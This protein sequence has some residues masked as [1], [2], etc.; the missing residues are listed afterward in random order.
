L[1]SNPELEFLMVSISG[2]SDKRSSIF[3]PGF[4]KTVTLGQMTVNNIEEIK[5]P[6]MQAKGITLVAMD[7]V[8]ETLEYMDTEE[9]DECVDKMGEHSRVIIDD[10][11][12]CDSMKPGVVK[13]SAFKT[14]LDH[15]AQLVTQSNQIYSYTTKVS[16]DAMKRQDPLAD[17]EIVNERRETIRTLAEPLERAGHPKTTP[18]YRI[19]DALIAKDIQQLSK[20]LESVFLDPKKCELLQSCSRREAKAIVDTFQLVLAREAV[21]WGQLAHPNLL[22]FYGLYLY[23]NRLSLVSPWAENGTLFDFMQKEKKAKR[24]QWETRLLLCS[25]VVEGIK[26]LHSND[27]IH[28][29]LKACNILV[30]KSHRAYLADFGFASVDQ[31]DL[32]NWSKHYSSLCGGDY[33]HQSPETAIDQVPNTKESD[34]FSFSMTCVEVF[35]GQVPFPNMTRIKAA[36]AI[37]NGKRPSLDSIPELTPELRQLVHDCWE[38]EPRNRPNIVEVAKRLSPMLPKDR[39]KRGEWQHESTMSPIRER[40]QNTR[41]PLTMDMLD[42]ILQRGQNSTSARA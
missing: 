26:Y 9:F 8:D 40:V 18:C 11:E 13:K 25:D 29:D 41:T 35:T 32:E 23:K 19:P 20:K 38:Q 15:A 14:N 34:I 31:K 12:R 3:S 39:R 42:Q 36:N 5:K 1:S 6:M 4:I 17:E 10:I 33:R 24:L 2:S 16:V 21:L 28:G 22:P 30:D 7:N 37:I 27:M